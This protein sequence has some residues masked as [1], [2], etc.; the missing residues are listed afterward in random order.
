MRFVRLLSKLPF[1][2][3]TSLRLGLYQL[4]PSE[5]SAYATAIWGKFSRGPGIPLY[6][7][8]NF[9]PSYVKPWGAPHPVVSSS[10][11]AVQY[12]RSCSLGLSGTITGS[13]CLSAGQ[14]FCSTP[15]KSK[16]CLESIK[17]NLFLP[18]K[19]LFDK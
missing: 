3:F 2:S 15:A 5:L 17:A 18:V 14:N 7:I 13:G 12:P 8:R 19:S 1:K 9:E 11:E 10:P 6:Q 16:T 4:I